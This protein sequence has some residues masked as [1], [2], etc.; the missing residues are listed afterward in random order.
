MWWQGVYEG[1]D[2]ENMDV[3]IHLWLCD[4]ALGINVIYVP[5][6]RLSLLFGARQ[7]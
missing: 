6:T 1:G 5:E 4:L 2:S 7:N 3:E